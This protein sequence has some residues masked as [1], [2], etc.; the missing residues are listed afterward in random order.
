MDGYTATR[1][2]RRDTRFQELP[3]IA[4][5]A[6]AMAGD[7]DKALAAGMN[8]H[9]AKPIDVAELFNVLHRWIQVDGVGQPVPERSAEL[10]REPAEDLPD[11]PDLNTRQ[12]LAHCAGNRALYR[13]IL[14]KF[15]ETQADAPQRIRAA[16]EG[17]DP[18]T[19]E[20]EAHTL[21]GLAGNIG[22]GELQAQA[23]DVE[24]RIRQGTDAGVALAALDRTLTTLLADLAAVSVSTGP[25]GDGAASL[26]PAD[27]N[28][29]LDRLQ[30]LLEEDDT[31]AIDLAAQIES[32]LTEPDFSHEMRA[33]NQSIGN[34]E[35]DDA[36]VQL[37]VLRDRL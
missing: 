30:M 11:L 21:K 22:A 32:Q 17:G 1:T 20:R 12:G 10:L 24:S 28:P 15:G 7:R 34:F 36:L 5:T 13:Q 3:I 25:T 31:D 27:L 19:A 23:G 26:A 4:M 6:N 16:L 14:Q 29:L 8:D 37:L 2:I 18:V 33:I 9:V 35:F